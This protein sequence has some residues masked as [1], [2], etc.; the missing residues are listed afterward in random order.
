M[1]SKALRGGKSENRKSPRTKAATPLRPARLPMRVRPG[2]AISS[3]TLA[4]ASGCQP[5][6]T[7]A[8]E[9]LPRARAPGPGG[10][11]ARPRDPEVG[12]PTRPCRPP[13][14]TAPRARQALRRA[15]APP[16]LAGRPNRVRYRKASGRRRG[17]ACPNHRYLSR[18]AT[19]G[20]IW[21]AR[22][23]GTNPAANATTAKLNAPTPITAAGK[24]STP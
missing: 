8:A 9:R 16:G 5:S 15:R 1:L 23:A 19:N 13:S 3:G 21:P 20:S 17:N 10:A 7:G 4:S 24:P 6:R 11:K 14:S 18:I 12:I 22:R 2:L